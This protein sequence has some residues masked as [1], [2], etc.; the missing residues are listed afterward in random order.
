MIGRWPDLQAPIFGPRR[1]LMSADYGG[2]DDQVLEVRII[3]HRLE[4]PPPNALRAPATE[5]TQDAVPIAEHLG[6]VASR[7]ACPHD[8]QHRFDEH[9]V[10]PA[11]R[12]LLVR[13]SNNQ[14]GHP[15]PCRVTQHQSIHHT[16]DRL[17]KSPHNL[18]FYPVPRARHAV[19]RARVVLPSGSGSE[20]EGKN[21]ASTTSRRSGC[22]WRSQVPANR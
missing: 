16:Q 6:K 17:P 20:C 14:R 10:V 15:L 5:P 12:S 4:Y 18:A 7:R 3:G 13:A 9:P 19:M 2:I 8:P 21:R 1:M 11:R 22:G